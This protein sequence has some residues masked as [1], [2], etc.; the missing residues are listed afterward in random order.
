MARYRVTFD[1]T[2]VDKADAS[3]WAFFI[4]SVSHGMK[5]V[6]V[7]SIYKLGPSLAPMPQEQKSSNEESTRRDGDSHHK[8]RIHRAGW[9]SSER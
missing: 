9:I 4:A 5:D 3:H 8:T 2:A 1:V 6:D 7:V